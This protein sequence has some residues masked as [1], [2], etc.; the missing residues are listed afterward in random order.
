MAKEETLYLNIDSNVGKVTKDVDKLDDATKK[1][2]GGFKGIGTAVKGVGTALKAAGIGLIVAIFAK[3]FQ[4]FSQNQKVLDAFSIANKAISIAFRDMFKLLSDNVGKVTGWFKELFEDP[5]QKLVDFGDAIKKNLIERFNSF[6]ETIGF[7]GE[8]FVKLI[9]R[10]FAGAMEAAKNA[11]GEFVDTLTGVDNTVSK[12]TKVIV[13]GT[14]KLVEYGKVVVDTATDM[15]ELDKAAGRASVT[16]AEQNAQFLKDAEDQRKIRDDVNKTFAE[17]ITANEKLGQILVDQEAAQLKQLKT[18]QSQAQAQFD[19]TGLEADYLLLQQAK[20]AI[21]ENEEAVRG[22]ASEQLTNQV[23]L[24]NELAEAIRQVNVESLTGM[25]REL[26]ELK[27][28]YDAKIDLARKA[29]IDN[30]AITEQ[31]EKEQNDIREKYSKKAKKWSEM[32]SEQQLGIASSTA[33]SLATILGEE[34][35]AGKAAAVVQATID[36]YAS[37]QAAYKS[38]AGIPVVGPALGAVAAAAAIAGGIKNINAIRGANESGASGGGG[39][40]PSA[41]SPTPA[42]QMMS[43]AFELGSGEEIEPTRAYV[44]SDDITAGQNALEI[45]RRRATI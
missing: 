35:A 9:N 25:E 10:D 13:E 26:E 45:I 24:E 8:A 38:L 12:V 3:L 23:A 44:V 32:S 17:R 22:Q 42:P 6:L 5:K 20:V 34:T 36:T 7:L 27:N 33:G 16:F 43:G 15:T 2:S 41:S 4:L 1:A 19:L 28:S 18:V 37:A 11:G 29:G 21:I 30:T 40:A 14:G 31:Y 39:G